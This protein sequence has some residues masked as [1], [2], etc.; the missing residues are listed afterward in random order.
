[1]LLQESLLKYNDIKRSKVKGKEIDHANIIPKQS[2]I[3][4]VNK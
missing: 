2:L 3:G 4:Y 1:M